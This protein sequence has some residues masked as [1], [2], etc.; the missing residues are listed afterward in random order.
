MGVN[1]GGIQEPPQVLA[2]AGNSVG[3]E[4]SLRGMEV[5]GSQGH[6]GSQKWDR[7]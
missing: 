4:G 6:R 3:G 7:I 2:P 5:G 1:V